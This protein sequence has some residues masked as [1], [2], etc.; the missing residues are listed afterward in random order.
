MGELTNTTIVIANYNRAEYVARAI[1]SCL[2]Q[3]VHRKMVEVIVV[4]DGSTDN[5]LDIIQ[6]FDNDIVVVRHEENK[7]LAAASNTGLRKAHGQYWMRVDSDDF[8]S[9][10]AVQMMALIL[11]SNPSTGFVYCDYARVDVQG[12]RTDTIKLNIEKKLMEYGS[13]ILFR[14]DLLKDIGGYDESLRNCEEYDLM[15]RLKQHDHTGFYLPVP[16]YRHYIH[17]KNM[18]LGTD[19]NYYKKLVNTKHGI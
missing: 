1:R 12:K 2:A 17:G 14:T 8:L 7:G 4:D 3:I 15:I 6:E 16:L 13:G 9:M 11:D 10:F 18:S 19:R 5:S